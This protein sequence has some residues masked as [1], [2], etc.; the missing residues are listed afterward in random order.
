MADGSVII[1]AGLISYGSWL[2][3]EPAG[4]LAAGALLLALGL[5]MARALR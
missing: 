4:F 5:G 3:F 1:G 2:I